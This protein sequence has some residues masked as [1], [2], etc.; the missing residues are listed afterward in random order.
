MRLYLILLPI[1]LFSLFQGAF[2]QLN[3]VLLTVLVWA[4]F[5]T[6]KESLLVA[7]ISGL[8]LDLAKGT[9][10]GASS[11]VLLV[12][13]Y[14]LRLYSRRFS[15]H[16][17][18][19]LAVFVGLTTCLWS[20]IFQGFFDWGQAVILGILAFATEV[21]LRFFWFPTQGKIKI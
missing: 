19:F 6:L 17:P 7:F 18:L 12:T 15:P 5:R 20:K 11:F 4:T 14:V 10:L 13:C 21:F 8:F 2:L 16:H 3:L 9:P 1:F